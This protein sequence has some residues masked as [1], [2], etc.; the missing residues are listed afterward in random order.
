MLPGSPQI[1]SFIIRFIHSETNEDEQPIRG[2]VRH[3]LSHQEIHFT[4]WQEAV[5]FINQF[6]PLEP[7]LASQGNAP[8]AEE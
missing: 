6:V 3:I 4:S 8:P 7:S 5:R 1:T 2:S